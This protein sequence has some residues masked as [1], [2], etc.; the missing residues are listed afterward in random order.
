M[1]ENRIRKS[2]TAKVYVLFKFNCLIKNF[3]IEY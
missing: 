2:K 1:K 3:L